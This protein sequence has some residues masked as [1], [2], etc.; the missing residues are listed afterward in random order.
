MLRNCTFKQKSQ[1]VEGRKPPDAA[2]IFTAQ[3]AGNTMLRNCT[4]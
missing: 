2:Y 4:I 1:N 3:H